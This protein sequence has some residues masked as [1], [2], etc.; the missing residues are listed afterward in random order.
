MQ[1][2]YG[3]LFTG[4]G[5]MG[6]IYCNCFGKLPGSKLSTNIDSQEQ[7]MRLELQDWLGFEFCTI[8]DYGTGLFL[9]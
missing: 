4:R 2:I 7:Q 3:H 8:K 9:K 1:N 5:R 6:N